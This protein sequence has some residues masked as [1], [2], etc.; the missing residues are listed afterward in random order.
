[1]GL[2]SA[3]TLQRRESFAVKPAGAVITALAWSPTAPELAVGGSSGL[4]QLWRVD[5]APR[6]TR[7]LIGLQPVLGKPEAIQALSFSP[8][9]QLLAASDNN[10]TVNALDSGYTTAN[11]P[12]NRL[13]SLAIWHASD[14]KLI[15]PPQDLGTGSARFDP[16]AFSPDGRLVAVSTPDGR[17]LVLDPHTAHKRQTIHPSGSEYTESIAFAPDGTLAT[18][19]IGGTVQL[20]NPISGKQVAGPL[21]V[22]AGPVSS[23]AFDPSGRRFATTGSQDGAVK[24]WSAST[25]QQEGTALDTNEGAASTAAFA[26]NGR[27][28]LV[29][30]NRG[31]AFTWPMSLAAW[32]RRACAIAGRN[33]TRAE[34]DRFLPGRGYARVCP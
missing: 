10:V 17:D 23:I 22:T 34:W 31:G 12:N 7:S 11:H 27:Q 21:S 32:E 3:R 1:V 19:T 4:V 20:W 18:G 6:L 9:G 15:A 24:L 28:L 5:G 26:P 2:F 14:G 13:S 29:T 30:D 8:D 16:L 33:L 25:L